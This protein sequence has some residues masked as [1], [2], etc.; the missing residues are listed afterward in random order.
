MITKTV[1]TETV[2]E[3]DENGKMVKEI[4]KTTENT[5]EKDTQDIYTNLSYRPYHPSYYTVTAES[6]QSG[7]ITSGQFSFKEE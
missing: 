5:Y 6:I 1:T 2:K 3:Y 7:V 4:I